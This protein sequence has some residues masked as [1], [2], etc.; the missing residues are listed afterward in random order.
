MTLAPLPSRPATGSPSGIVP[1]RRS[2]LIWSPVAATVV[3]AVPAIVGVLTGNLLLFPSLGPT[4]LMQAHVPEHESSRPYNVLVSHVGGLLCA[5]LAVTIFGVARAPSVFELHALP[6]AR[7]WASLVAIFL[8]TL[9][10]I[11]L[12]A[13]H[14]P[15]AATTLLAALGS[16]KRSWGDAT[17]VVCGLLL[18]LVAGEAVRRLRLAAAGRP[19]SAPPIG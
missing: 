12:D 13:A 11:G 8:A 15:A 10:E 17:L 18:V 16:F 2:N 1:D 9:L 14:P 5:Y 6:A 7:V 19:P 4:A 3:L